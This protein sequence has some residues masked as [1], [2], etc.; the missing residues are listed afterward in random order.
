MTPRIASDA[1]TTPSRRRGWLRRTAIGVVTYALVALAASFFGF[2]FFG[3]A[4]YSGP[5]V[6]RVSDADGHG[7]DGAFVAYEW[8]G[9]SLHGSTG[10]KAAAIVRSG[11]GGIYFVPWQGWRLFTATGWG[12]TPAGPAIWAPGYVAI[13]DGHGGSTLVPERKKA[14][15]A[16]LALTGTV[17]KG[18]CFGRPYR[19]RWIEL[20]QEHFQRS[21]NQVCTV[22][23]SST[24]IDLSRLSGELIAVFLAHDGAMLY[25]SP[26]TTATNEK[27]RAMLEKI[28]WPGRP[29]A[30]NAQTSPEQ[31]DDFC[32]AVKTD[33]LAFGG[34]LHEH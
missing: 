22:K 34:Q 1:A 30:S 7:I 13:A 5:L 11:F 17:D 27:Y 15:G 19:A 6:G 12:I 16:E 25:G 29:E 20:R 31:R 14:V 4:F 24:V 21:Y 9:Q 18:V 10:C 26:T 32:V 28:A 8:S 33:Y 2:N 23:T 3:A